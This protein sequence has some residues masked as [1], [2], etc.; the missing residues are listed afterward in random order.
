[1]TVL[2]LCEF[3]MGEISGQA[4]GQPSVESILGLWRELVR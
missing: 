3:Y 1:M 4:D 2:K